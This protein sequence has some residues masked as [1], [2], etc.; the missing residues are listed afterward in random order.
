MQQL[1]DFFFSF[2]LDVILLDEV[3]CVYVCSATLFSTRTAVI[4]WCKFGY[5]NRI[6]TCEKL[7]HSPAGKMQLNAWRSAPALPLLS[8]GNDKWRHVDKIAL[9][10]VR[11]QKMIWKFS[12]TQCLRITHKVSFLLPIGS[13]ICNLCYKNR[14]WGFWWFLQHCDFPGIW[15]TNFFNGYFSWLNVAFRDLVLIQL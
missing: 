2:S 3:N 6:I 7:S 13:E 1:L 12:K 14:F 9:S 5:L 10:R 4:D 11:P 8:F 15:S